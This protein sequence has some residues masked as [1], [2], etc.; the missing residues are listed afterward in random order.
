MADHDGLLPSSQREASNTKETN[1]IRYVVIKDHV[2]IATVD[3]PTTADEI[4][5][6]HDA[7]EIREYEDDMWQDLL[8][9]E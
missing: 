7:D 1:M 4:Y 5:L 3:D 9:D 6:A 8:S 2:P